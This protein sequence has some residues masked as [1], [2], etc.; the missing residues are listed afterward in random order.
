MICL[1][2]PA[3]RLCEDQGEAFVDGDWVAKCPECGRVHEVDDEDEPE[4]AANV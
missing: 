2:E 1:P 3:C 4:V